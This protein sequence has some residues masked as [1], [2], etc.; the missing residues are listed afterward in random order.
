MNE[1]INQSIKQ[2]PTNQGMSDEQ[3]NQNQ[4][5]SSKSKPT[6]II[7]LNATNKA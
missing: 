7:K 1:S 5:E 6:K 3:I 4:P 2:L